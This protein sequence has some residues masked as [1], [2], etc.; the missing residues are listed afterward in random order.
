[1]NGWVK[2]HRQVL[3][4]EVFR[5][6]R[7]AWHV[8]ETLLILADSKTGKWSGGMYQL[9]DMC[10]IKRPTLYK[11]VQRLEL[12]EMIKR[13]VNSRYT[14]YYICKWNEYQ[15]G[16]ETASKHSVNGEETAS[17][18]L[19]RNK[20]RELEIVSKDT[21]AKAEIN[22][23]FDYWVRITGLPITARIKQNRYACSNLIKKHA[24]DGV[25]RLVGGVA[26]A[27][28]DKYAPRISDFSQLQS[29]LGDLLLW[30]KKQSNK[31]KGVKIK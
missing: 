28:D 24:V 27:H 15:G 4:N 11:A 9:A 16:R 3:E 18:T 22:E 7:T 1:M 13:S 23:M 8:F 29:K 12:T 6:D 20:N 14:V 17:N 31:V 19:T 2:L 30:G 10:E 25:K 21:M 26:Q 5:H